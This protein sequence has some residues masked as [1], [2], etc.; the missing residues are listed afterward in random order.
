MQAIIEHEVDRKRKK[1]PYTSP[2]VIT[3][4]TFLVKKKPTCLNK[5][6]VQ[7]EKYQQNLKCLRH[8]NGLSPIR[9]NDLYYMH[10]LLEISH[11][12]NIRQHVVWGKF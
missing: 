4:L 11:F 2:N 10:L 3:M 8:L 5:Y 7:Q 1:T 6:K 9:T 12:V